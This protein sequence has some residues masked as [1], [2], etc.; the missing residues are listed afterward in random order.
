M[1]VAAVHWRGETTG[2]ELRRQRGSKAARMPEDDEQDEEDEN[3]KRR[4]W[5]TWSHLLNSFVHANYKPL[6]TK[7]SGADLDDRTTGLALSSAH[8]VPSQLQDVLSPE[9]PFLVSSDTQSQGVRPRGS[10]EW[11]EQ[12]RVFFADSTL[13]P[14]SSAHTLSDAEVTSVEMESREAQDGRLAG[15]DEAGN[16]VGGV[17]WRSWVDLGP[18]AVDLGL[19]AVDGAVD[20]VAARIVRWTDDAGRDEEL[21]LPLAKG[22]VE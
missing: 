21:V 13:T 10:A 20:R 12:H 11:A 18:A 6:L 4:G 15:A 3:Q 19:A 5:K 22:K 17:E 9:N 7:P 1:V 8:D 16:R 2:M 14:G